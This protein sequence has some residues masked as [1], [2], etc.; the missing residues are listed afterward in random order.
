MA[1]VTIQAAVVNDKGRVRGN[2]EDSFLLNG[3]YMARD[4]MNDGKVLTATSKDVYQLYSVCDGMGG[5]DA[6]EEASFMAVSELAR[7]QG[8]PAGIYRADELKQVLR[9]ISDKIYADSC[10][11]NRNS[12]T[13]MV[14][15][16]VQGN[17]ATIAHVGD[18]RIYRL[19]GK[20]LEQVTEDHSEVQRLVALGIITPE[21]ARTHPRRNVISQYMGMPT[22]VRV[23]PT[24]QQGVELLKDDVYMLCSDGLSDMVED[25][26]IETILNAN[27]NPKAAAQA[28]VNE[29]LKNGG[30]DNVTVMVFRVTEVKH[31]TTAEKR[32]RNNNK[33][34]ALLHIGRLIVGAGLIVTLADYIFYLLH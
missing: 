20:K 33:I 5:I 34:S 7:Y 12:G 9:Y 1:N 28:L 19:R 10:A 26:V 3:E 24:V 30:K 14:M 31:R 11:N 21:E 29:A 18:S 27:P 4:K 22:D 2:N 23:S 16:S 8:Q 13:T 6:G 32:Y 25:R 15:V 17:S